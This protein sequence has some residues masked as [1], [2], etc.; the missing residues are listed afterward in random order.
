MSA[1]E[2]IV[3][4]AVVNAVIVLAAV[5]ALLL[6]G[7]WV[8]QCARHEARRAERDRAAVRALIRQTGGRV[9]EWTP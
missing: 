6:L 8:E 9:G 2:A 1:T 5:G 7:A 4:W 3:G